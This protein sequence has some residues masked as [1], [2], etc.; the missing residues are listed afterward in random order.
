MAR[1][2]SYRTVWQGNL[3]G[4]SSD[5]SNAAEITKP[6]TANKALCAPQRKTRIA[7]VAAVGALEQVQT[8]RLAPAPFALFV[9]LLRF[10]TSFQSP[11]RLRADETKGRGRRGF[12]LIESRRATLGLFRKT[13]PGRP[14]LASR[15]SDDVESHRPAPW[16]RAPS[17]GFGA[18]SPLRDAPAPGGRPARRVPTPRGAAAARPGRFEGDDATT[19]IRPRRLERGAS[20]AGF[21]GGS[22]RDRLEKARNGAGTA[23]SARAGP[24]SNRSGATPSRREGHSP[25][26]DLASAPRPRRGLASG[27]RAGEISPPSPLRVRRACWQWQRAGARMTV[28]RADRLDVERVVETRA[29]A[30]I[31]H[32]EHIPRPSLSRRPLPRRMPRSI[33]LCQEAA[34]LTILEPRQQE[35]RPR[36][37]RI[38]RRR[39]RRRSAA[40][41]AAT[42]HHGRCR[43]GGGGAEVRRRK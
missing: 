23:S 18:R 37:R 41:L 10:D 40:H 24:L 7:L 38:R 32:E 19:A 2:A 20:N 34:R 27:D 13:A 4:G 22:S 9:V 39:F 25:R 17:N 28:Y 15:R 6:L 36:R 26:R 3:E 14:P 31:E 35:E 11:P 12:P 42:G 16:E 29:R 33:S 5:F 8:S 43:G 21:R 30:G 1:D